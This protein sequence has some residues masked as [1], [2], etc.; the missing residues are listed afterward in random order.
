[1]RNSCNNQI[2]INSYRVKIGHNS[3]SLCVFVLSWGEHSNKLISQKLAK[4]LTAQ[5]CDT[6]KEQKKRKKERSEVATTQ[7]TYAN[8]NNCFVRCRFFSLFAAAFLSFCYG[9]RGGASASNGFDECILCMC[10][11]VPCVFHIYFINI[12][13]WICTRAAPCS[14]HSQPSMWT[15]HFRLVYLSSL[16]RFVFHSLHVLRY[17]Y[18]YCP[19]PHK[20]ASEAKLYV[21]CVCTNANVFFRKQNRRLVENGSLA[22]NM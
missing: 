15:F 20:S 17:T 10:V 6:G 7:S 21:Y 1:M 2:I 5:K 16:F 22:I 9:R 3:R 11:C 14:P 4:H 8:R 18:A 13:I 12:F 19:A